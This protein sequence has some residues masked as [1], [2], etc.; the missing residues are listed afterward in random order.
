MQI[1][2]EEEK[3]RRKQEK[4][5]NP[6]KQQNKTEKNLLQSRSTA[7]EKFVNRYPTQLML[8][9][10]LMLVTLEWF[11]WRSLNMIYQIY[12]IINDRCS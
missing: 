4:G 9:F 3:K 12:V 8:P 7:K 2:L 6:N 1:F 11:V 10:Y 5:K